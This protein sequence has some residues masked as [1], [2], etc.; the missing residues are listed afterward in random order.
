MMQLS[1]M[2]EIPK[3]AQN[4]VIWKIYVFIFKKIEM[5]LCSKLLNLKLFRI[6]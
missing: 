5:F 2:M 1:E 6:I 4:Y 3:V